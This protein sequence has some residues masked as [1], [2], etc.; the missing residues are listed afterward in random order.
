MQNIKSY[1]FTPIFREK[2]FWGWIGYDNCKEEKTWHHNKVVALHTVAKN[3]GLRLNE[4]KKTKKLK[5]GLNLLENHI[6]GTKQAVWEYNI[7]KNK[8]KFSYA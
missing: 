3:I 2:K 4:H 8:A 5:K 6:K 7:K 1:L